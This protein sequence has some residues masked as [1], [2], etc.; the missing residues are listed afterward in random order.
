[1]AGKAS[2]PPITPETK[3]GDLLRHYPELEEALVTLSPAYKALKNP[4]LRRT[5]AKVATLRQVAT[6]G[7][8]SLGTLIGRLRAAAGQGGGEEFADAGPAG[9]RP[10][11]ADPARVSRTY[12]ARA[13][14]ESGGHPVE[15]AMRDLNGLQ[16]GEVYE[17]ITPFVPAPLVD[18][19]AR[20][21]FRAFSTQESPEL[22]R[23]YF[24]RAGS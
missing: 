18:L 7:G 6:V 1:M 21:G 24:T 17:L 19:A 14:I 4:V 8:I 13:T 20:K 5:V 2:R 9:P 23:T 15:Q 16:E 12:D 11:W 10:E 22:V 3:V